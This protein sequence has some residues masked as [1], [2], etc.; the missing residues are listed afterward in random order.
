[1]AEST[2]TTSQKIDKAAA[3]MNETLHSAGK[4]VEAAVDKAQK[5]VKAELNNQTDHADHSHDAHG[6]EGGHDAHA[7]GHGHGPELGR[8]VTHPP[9]PPQFLQV[10]YK[11]EQKALIKEYV[12]TH[13]GQPEP[14]VVEGWMEK[15]PV[16]G[17]LKAVEGRQPTLAQTLHIGRLDKPLPLVNYLPWENH[18]FLA[19]GAIVTLGVFTVLSSSLRGDRRQ[20]IRRPSR[21][22]VALEAIASGLDDLCKGVLGDAN[23]RFYMPFVATMFCFI[24]ICN[25]MGMVPLM[26]PPTA[27]IVITLSLALCTFMVV[28]AT[29]WVRLGPL[30]YLHHLMGS[31]KDAIGWILSPLFL[32]LECISDFVAKPLSLALR[33][34]GN[35]LGKEILFGAFL[36]M[37]IALV[38]AVS[39]ALS[40]YI[41]F[42]LTFPFYALGL[43]LSTIQALVFSLLSV[44]YIM[45]VLPHDDHHDDDHGVGDHGHGDHAHTDHHHGHAAPVAKAPV[46]EALPA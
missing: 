17:Q 24:L 27:S 31:P 3:D 10:Y 20:A 9:E 30:N 15:D 18:V 2:Q 46:H 11:L 33:L 6:A 43:L 14:S 38:A 5:T 16:T 32:L 41:G 35:M 4:S 26:K 45:L 23:G 28:Q 8:Y 44:I 42:P 22:Q 34:M 40:H 7:A 12:A 37:G 39:P 21:G 36:G 25:L 13:P 29:A 19:I 1:M